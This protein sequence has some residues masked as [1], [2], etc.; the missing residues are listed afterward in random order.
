MTAPHPSPGLVGVQVWA[1]RSGRPRALDSA[2]RPELKTIGLTQA[3]SHERTGRGEPSQALKI[4]TIPALLQD[5]SL[6]EPQVPPPE[7]GTMKATQ[8]VT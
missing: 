5:P 3:S 4:L 7:T 1:P 8:K 2:H 6:L